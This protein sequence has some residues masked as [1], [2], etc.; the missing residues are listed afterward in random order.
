MA[1]KR[2]LKDSKT[3]RRRLQEIELTPAISACPVEIKIVVDGKE[4]YRLPRIERKNILHWKDLVLPCDLRDDSNLTVQITEIRTLRNRVGFAVYRM[5]QA[6]NSDDLSTECY[7]RIYTSKVVFQ[8]QDA[9]GRAY[10][11]ALAKAQ[12]MESRGVL[13][14]SGPVGTAFKTLLDLGSALSELDPT[15]GS[16]V[17]FTLCTKAWEHM[18]KQ[19]KQAAELDDLV[20]SLARMAPTIE[21]VQRIAD[22]N[23]G[24]TTTAILNLI[25]DASLFILNYKS[26]NAFGV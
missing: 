16:K 7:N 19:E 24:D 13:K 2:P 20:Q 9:A 11:E 23:L 10:T 5:S 14:T 25:E 1:S 6:A 22:A 26:R 8:S 21:S 18:E 15:G 17:A 3:S 4:L 12:Q